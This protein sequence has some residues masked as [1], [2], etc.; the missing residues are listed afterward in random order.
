VESASKSEETD[1]I[2]SNIFTNYN[3]DVHPGSDRADG[4]VEVGVSIIPLF[5]D[6]VRST[7]VFFLNLLSS[8]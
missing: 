3:K 1:R 2:L 4:A 8:P 6:I 7:N 5:I